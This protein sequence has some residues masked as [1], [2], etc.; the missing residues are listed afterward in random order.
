MGS[1]HTR[2]TRP[3]TLSRTCALGF[4]K[5]C[6]LNQY[7]RKLLWQEG[8]TSM[9]MKICS[10]LK[11]DN[12][13]VNIEGPPTQGSKLDSGTLVSFRVRI[14]REENPS[15]SWKPRKFWYKMGFSSVPEWMIVLYDHNQPS[16]GSDPPFCGT[17][18][19]MASACTAKENTQGLCYMTWW[20]CC[21]DE[22][23]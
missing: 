20:F 1:R 7:H 12:I 8:R 17:Y 22:G 21:I 23:F 10:T 14:M 2:N 9:R 6:T 16:L 11:D 4:N 19:F 18:S 3:A 5:I 13:D 15:S